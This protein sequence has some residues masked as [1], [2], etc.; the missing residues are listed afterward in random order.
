ML[1]YVYQ[2][3]SRDCVVAH[4]VL[5]N[6]NDINS[7]IQLLTNDLLDRTQLGSQCQMYFT[8]T[9][10][11]FSNTILLRVGFVCTQLLLDSS[12]SISIS[13]SLVSI[14]CR[15]F[16]HKLWHRYTILALHLLRNLHTAWF[17]WARSCQ[18]GSVPDS[19]VDV[20][21]RTTATSCETR[22]LNFF[23]GI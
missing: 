16:H 8:V 20:A 22:D 3:R 21:L 1:R 15:S 23:D 19:S 6:L 2:I 5:Q 12:S 14:R 7:L 4:E 9:S 11:T 10:M 13:F 17:I 18:F